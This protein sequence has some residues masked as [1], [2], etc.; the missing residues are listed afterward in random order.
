ML[1]YPPLLLLGSLPLPL[2][3]P[4]LRLFVLI[5]FR[6]SWLRGFLRIMLLSSI[7]AAATWSSSVFTSFYL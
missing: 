7:L 6:V 5:A 3:C 2:L 4:V 1:L